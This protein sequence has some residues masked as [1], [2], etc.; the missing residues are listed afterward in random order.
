MSSPQDRELY[1]DNAATTYPKPESVCQAVDRFVRVQGGAYG[2]GGHQR[3]QQATALV[4][5]TRRLLSDLL[6]IISPSQLV[7]TGSGTDGLNMAIH[8]L[9]KPGDHVITTLLEHN[10]VLRPLEYLRRLGVITTTLLAPGEDGRM[11]P[12]LVREHLLPQTR[13]VCC[14]H[15][16]NVTGILQPIESIG[17][18][19]REANVVFLVDGAQTAGHVEICLKELPVD[20]FVTSGHKGLL[21]ILGTGLLYLK[22]GLEQEIDPY[23]QGG[24]GTRSA[25]LDMPGEMPAR[26]EAGNHNLP[27]IASLGAAAEYLNRTGVGALHKHLCELTDQAILQLRDIE[28]VRIIHQQTSRDLRVG[29]LS[30]EFESIEP[31][32]AGMILDESFQIQVRTGLHCAPLVHRHLGTFERGGTVRVS[33]G[34]FNTREDVSRLVKAV[35]QIARS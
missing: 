23:R 1:L 32:I 26:F 4:E 19:C 21:G 27:G 7:F 12:E 11:D 20:L 18:I 17:R 8:G 6:G 16:S 13:L 5:Q 31:Q 29:L 2:R 28:G 10:S 30:F 33:F 24:T 25:E 9:L 3:G 22:S 34:A 14:T 35:E 15:A